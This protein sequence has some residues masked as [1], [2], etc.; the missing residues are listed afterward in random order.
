MSVELATFLEQLEG[1]EF[2]RFMCVLFTGLKFGNINSNK[3]YI[4]KTFLSYSTNF[5][6]LSNGEYTV[7]FKQPLL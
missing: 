4:K 3:N 5:A 1:W 2:D 7:Y 6:V